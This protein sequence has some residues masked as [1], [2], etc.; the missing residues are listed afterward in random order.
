MW[1]I[2]GSAILIMLGL[3]LI[4]VGLVGTQWTGATLVGIGLAFIAWEILG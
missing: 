3:L 4:A 1:A 2:A